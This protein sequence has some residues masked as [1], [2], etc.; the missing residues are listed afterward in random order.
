MTRQYPLLFVLSLTASPLIAQVSQSALLDTVRANIYIHT[1]SPEQQRTAERAIATLDSAPGSSAATRLEAHAVL[2]EYL[3]GYLDDDDGITVHAK[4]VMALAGRLDSAD[5]VR[6]APQLIHAYR[7]LAEVMAGHGDIQSAVDLLTHA[8]AALP[9]VPD[10]AAGLADEVAR[11]RLIGQAPPPIAAPHWFNAA[12]G[13]TLDLSRGCPITIVEFSAYWCH[14]CVLSYPDLLAVQKKYGANQ[15]RLVVVTNLLG[16]FRGDTGLTL[17]VELARLKQYFT[18]EQGLTGP[19]AVSDR[20]A[21]EESYG[22]IADA[23]HVFFI[24]ETLIIDSRG[25]V[26]RIFVG[27]DKRNGDRVD[28][29]VRLALTQRQR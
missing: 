17:D 10:V 25:R 28:Q 18:Q 1:V 4:T 7:D 14:G 12:D 2:E 9:G 24:P 8:P 29:A 23:Y 15:V 20:P 16:R 26:A 22:L 13:T 21:S 3:R 5:R 11:Y 27:W 6:L 19:I